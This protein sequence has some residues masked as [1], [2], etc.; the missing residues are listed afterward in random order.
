MTTVA[1]G[2]IE[3]GLIPFNLFVPTKRGRL[4]LFCRAGFPVTEKHMFILRNN[5]RSI[6]ISGDDYESY[7]GYAS[8]RIREIIDDRRI[9]VDDKAGIVHGIARRAIKKVLEKPQSKESIGEA[10]EVVDVFLDLI[11]LSPE[12]AGHLLA[13]SSLNPYEFSHSINVCTFCLLLGE[14]LLGSDVETLQQVG[15]GGLL[16]DVGKTQIDPMII[17]KQGKLT[18]EE[19]QEVRRHSVLGA[20]IATKHGL[21]DIV[22]EICRS[23]HERLDGSGY[24]DGLKG[25][26]LGRAA[27][28]AAIADVYDALTSERV[29][30]RSRHHLDALSVIATQIEGF[31]PAAFGALLDIVLRNDQLIVNFCSKHFDGALRDRIVEAARKA[32]KAVPAHRRIAH[33]PP[34][35]RE[36]EAGMAP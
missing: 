35:D 10:R 31:D 15:I 14:R 32:A 3:L 20:E 2:S 6:Y 5:D 18:D 11:R 23:H 19:Y 7:I 34:E 17:F 25:A 28:I 21:P 26:D 24:P 13:L 12:A 27:R 22:V 4:V 9:R 33:K 29:Y 30:S 16:H 36:I 8:K 1:A